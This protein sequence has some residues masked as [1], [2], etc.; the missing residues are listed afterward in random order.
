PASIG[1]RRPIGG[2]WTYRCR[3][4]AAPAPSGAVAPSAAGPYGALPSRAGSCPIDVPR[5]SRRALPEVAAVTDRPGARAYGITLLDPRTGRHYEA[6]GVCI[7]IG[8]GHECEVQ[9][10][11]APETVVS[12]IHAELTVSPAGWLLVILLVLMLLLAG[13]LSSVYRLV[14]AQVEQ[15]ERARR[16]GEVVTPQLWAAPPRRGQRPPGAPARA[17]RSRPAWSP[18]AR[19]TPSAVLRCPARTYPP[20]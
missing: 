20:C 2:P 19:Q 6:R 12:R 5:E 4:I 15:T 3:L 10:V 13:A 1:G 14:S 18:S 16:A 9:P 7:R 8:R 11:D 17:S